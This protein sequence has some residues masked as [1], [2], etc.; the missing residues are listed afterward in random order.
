MDALDQLAPG[1]VAHESGE[2]HRLLVETVDDYAIFALDPQGYVI[3]W[4]AGAQRIKG[5]KPNEII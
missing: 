2:L 1:G 5:Y 4:N 3:S